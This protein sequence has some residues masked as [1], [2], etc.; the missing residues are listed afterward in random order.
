MNLNWI[1]V[2]IIYCCSAL[3]KCHRVCFCVL[4]A[5]SEL[6]C[7]ACSFKCFLC[8]LSTDTQPLQQWFN[9]PTTFCFHHLLL[10]SLYGPVRDVGPSHTESEF[11]YCLHKDGSFIGL[12]CQ[13]KRIVFN[14]S[15]FHSNGWY[16]PVSGSVWILP[17]TKKPGR[18]PSHFTK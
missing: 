4:C 13:Y 7:C 17:I 18:N 5:G 10:Y 6:T 2:C 9:K 15:L 11:P 16:D 14:T 1:V 12:E 3:G 8:D